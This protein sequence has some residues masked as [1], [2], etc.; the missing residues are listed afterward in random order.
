M[1]KSEFHTVKSIRLNYSEM[2]MALTHE[3]ATSLDVTP[4]GWNLDIPR[5]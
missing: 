5:L 1:R 2:D 3:R 4:V